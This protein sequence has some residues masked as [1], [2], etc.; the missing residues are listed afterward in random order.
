MGTPVE[1]VLLNCTHSS[2]HRNML[3]SLVFA[4]CVLGCNGQQNSDN[5]TRQPA[6]EGFDKPMKSNARGSFNK[7]MT[8][9]NAR[10]SFNKPIMNN[11][12]RG[13]FNKPMMNNN[14]RGSFN[15]PMMNNNAWERQMFNGNSMGRQQFGDRMGMSNMYN[16]NGMGQRMWQRGDDFMGQVWDDSMSGSWSNEDW[17][18]DW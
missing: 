15:K 18:G 16:G 11:N 9:S 13:S 6:S 8:N 3:L 14:A 4:L 5:S 10:G 2:T 1:C 7:P 12:A 17:S